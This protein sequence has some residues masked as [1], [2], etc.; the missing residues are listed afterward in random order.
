MFLFCSPSPITYVDASI[1]G[2]PSS[3]LSKSSSLLSLNHARDEEMHREFTRCKGSTGASLRSKQNRDCNNFATDMCAIVV[4]DRAWVRS[5]PARLSTARSHSDAMARTAQSTLLLTIDSIN[6]YRS[7]KVRL[8]LMGFYFLT[9]S[10]TRKIAH[11]CTRSTSR[12]KCYCLYVR[13]EP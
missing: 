1:T 8:K 5:S 4:I 10:T 13:V 3:F 11:V 6:F 7:E 9:P 12:A 2:S